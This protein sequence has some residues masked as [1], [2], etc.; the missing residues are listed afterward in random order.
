MIALGNDPP[1]QGGRVAVAAGAGG[2]MV[3][4]S[5]VNGV[6][7]SFVR[8]GSL[9]QAGPLFPIAPNGRRPSLA[10]DGR[11]FV[12]AWES[13]GVIA[14]GRVSPAGPVSDV[15]VMNADGDQTAAAP[16]ITANA[17]VPA[18]IAFAS[19]HPADEGV[20][21]GA[22]LF[23]RE[24]IAVAP[25]PAPVILGAAR[26]S[27]DELTVSW[28]PV[29]NAHGVAVEVQLGDGT[30][31]GIGH[32]SADAAAARVSLA[33]LS[34]SRVRVRAWNASGESE[35]SASIEVPILKRRSAR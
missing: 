10:F 33:G 20:F 30:F 24:L 31:R 17:Q 23:A 3:L 14:T 28:R 16:I 32:A 19:R 34:P 6:Y 2:Y 18:L 11:D 29:P 8:R 5:Q 35:P 26:T 13:N 4:W 7:G 12:A 9:A 21:R 15:R 25:P 1:D 22:L 27:S